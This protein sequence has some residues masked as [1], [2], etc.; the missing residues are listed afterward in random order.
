M[1]TTTARRKVVLVQQFL[2]QQMAIFCWLSTVR[3]FIQQC[4]LI[5]DSLPL[6]FALSRG[7]AAFISGQ[8]TKDRHLLVEELLNKH[9]PLPC[10]CRLPRPRI[11]RSSTMTR[12]WL[13]NL[14]TRTMWLQRCPCCKCFDSPPLCSP[15]LSPV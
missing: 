2:Q 12:I 9:Y 5:Y 13:F 11:S 15:P 10:V 3:N 1:Q 8:S 4:S 7:I 6:F 14:I